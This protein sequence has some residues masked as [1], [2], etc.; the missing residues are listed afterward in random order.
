MEDTRGVCRQYLWFMEVPPRPLTHIRLQSNQHKPQGR[1]W[2]SRSVRPGWVAWF[3]NPL[4]SRGWWVGAAEGRA[5]AGIALCSPGQAGAPCLQ[6][7]P[8]L[9]SSP[10]QCTYL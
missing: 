5:V 1:C 4:P 2:I 7:K 9:L 10:F 8:A 3:S 6:G